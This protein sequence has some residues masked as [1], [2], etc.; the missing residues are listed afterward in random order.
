[1]RPSPTRRTRIAVVTVS[2]ITAAAVGLP[3]ARPSSARAQ[4]AGE[5]LT[6][7]EARAAAERRAP[8]RA[9]AARRAALAETDVAIARALPNPTFTV[10]T[11]RLTARLATGVSLPMPLFGQRHLATA[12]AR[13]DV[14]T[15]LRESGLGQ[16]ELR[17]SATMAWIDAWEAA[18]RARLVA[19]GAADADRLLE[20]ARA[21]F[22]AG[23]A[24]RLD[25]VRATADRARARAD[26][27][28][29]G[30]LVTAA[31][32][33]LAVWV[34]AD[35]IAPPGV[36]GEPG[37][38]AALPDLAALVEALEISHPALER[39]RAEERSAT[40]RADLERRLRFPVVSADLMVSQL[41]P[42]TPGTDVLAGASFELPILDRRA[43]AIAHAERQRD[44][45]AA[46]RALDA[47][48]LRA[49][50]VDAYHRTRS[51]ARRAREI[52]RSAL[53]AS[54][55]A[56]ALTEE[57]YRAGRA[58]LLRVLDAQRAVLELRLAEREAVAT[59]AR[60]FA[61]L[62]RAVGAAVPQGESEPPRPPSS[63]WPPLLPPNPS[64]LAQTADAVR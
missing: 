29:A 3:A 20:I 33:H 35:P 13:A 6:W 39:D 44:V 38:P 50:L 19:L 57:S 10:T 54:E 17:W 22:E 8:E 15:A 5:T 63:H 37:V 58:D 1:M 25:V 43:G 24:P 40:A 11:S 47:A 59:W 9:L 45:F 62:E 14:D 34:G 46:T 23:S 41:D 55:E 48:H 61:D 28:G 42:T 64:P 27:E 16:S 60:A 2:C 12:V 21:R 26:A 31:A 51:G 30:P 53:P 7:A 52:G 56:R 49:D 18:A 36:V 32:A 4:T